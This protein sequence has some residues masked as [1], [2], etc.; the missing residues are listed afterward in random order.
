MPYLVLIGSLLFFAEFMLGGSFAEAEDKS[1]IASKVAEERFNSHVVPLVRKYCRGCHGSSHAEADLNLESFVKTSQVAD[2]YPTWKR[3]LSRLEQREMPPANVDQPTDA[4]RKQAIQALKDV[5]MHLAEVHAGDPGPVLLRR[6]T[7]AEYDNTIHDLTGVNLRL[8][9]EFPGDGA[10]GEGF[11]N[12]GQSLTLSAE[13]LDKYVEAAQQIASRALFLTDG[14][15]AFF[16]EPAND[17]PGKAIALLSDRINTRYEQLHPNPADY[18]AA[19]WEFGHRQALGSPLDSLEEAARHWKL[20]ANYLSSIWMLL[21]TEHPTLILK[22]LQDAWRGLSTEST[23]KASAAG[24]I[25]AVRKQ[26]RAIFQAILIDGLDAVPGLVTGWRDLLCDNLGGPQDLDVSDNRT[27][28]LTLPESLDQE[29]KQPVR[30]HFLTRH[31]GDAEGKIFFRDLRFVP[32]EPEKEP[33]GSSDPEKK[34]PGPIRLYDWLAWNAPKQLEGLPW[35]EHP[36]DQALKDVPLMLIASAVHSIELPLAAARDLAGWTLQA[37]VELVSEKRLGEDYARAMAFCQASLRGGDLPS[38]LPVLWPGEPIL[39][40]G[41]D[42]QIR[43]LASYGEFQKWYRSRFAWRPNVAV[44]SEGDARGP[45]TPSFVR[46]YRHRFDPDNLLSRIKPEYH[47]NTDGFG[48]LRFLTAHRYDAPLRQLVLDPEQRREWDQLYRDLWVVG[49][50]PRRSLDNFKHENRT[51]LIE[52]LGAT[53]PNDAITLAD[54][55]IEETIRRGFFVDFFGKSWQATSVDHALAIYHWIRR[56]VRQWEEDYRKIEAAQ[57]EGLVNFAER[58]WRRPLQPS[59]ATQLRTFYTKTAQQAEIDRDEVLRTVMVRTLT[60]PDFLFRVER[61]PVSNKASPVTDHELAVRL[62]YFLWASPPDAGLRRAADTGRLREREVLRSQTRRMLKDTRARRF[63][64]EFFGQM[65][66][67]ANFESYRGPD[68]QRFP[69]FTDDLRS[70]MYEEP[71]RLLEK[72]V[73]DD[74][75][76]D[77]ILSADYT[78]VNR[79]LARHYGLEVPHYV[80]DDQTW[81]QADKVARVDRGGLLGMA[82][83]LTRF[84]DSLRTSPVRRGDW[85]NRALLGVKL[86]LPPMS[87][88]ELPAEEDAGDGLTLRQRLARHREDSACASCHAKFDGYGFALEG[89]DPIGRRRTTDGGGRRLDLRGSVEGSATFEGF[90]GLRDFLRLR[91]DTFRRN[92]CEKLVGY[93]LGR[94]ILLSDRQLVDRMASELEQNDGRFSVLVTTLVDSQQFRYRRGAESPEE[95]ERQ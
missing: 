8:A 40:T 69:E 17:R 32:P 24:G 77:E 73:R 50:V 60:S 72:I 70:A 21:K 57:V 15:I 67:F 38:V 91:R 68:P 92:L 31:V 19:A 41:R 47:T 66:Q 13:L 90:A 95:E 25:A 36:P 94:T 87:V 22:T 29:R 1:P 86:P 78:L 2:A 39:S 44:G 35:D 71:V 23:R 30:I 55:K 52:G 89:F 4:E 80:Q 82:A 65:Y 93:A 61:E 5:F 74:R 56:D 79:S 11:T 83:L 34:P 14:T 85:I 27:V 51:N 28:S 26:V 53:N 16:A 75:S 62:S 3:A 58:A 37:D 76:V 43:V 42:Q 45:Q 59:E 7:N 18:Y 54:D 33:D 46:E 48:N 10:A 49:R 9:R 64:E 88:P 6:L 12:T 63:V 84:S 20:S 81:W